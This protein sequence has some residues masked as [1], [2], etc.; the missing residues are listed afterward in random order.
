MELLIVGL[1][2]KLCYVLASKVPANDG[3]KTDA[4]GYCTWLQGATPLWLIGGTQ[5]TTKKSPDDCDGEWYDENVLI[6]LSFPFP[7]AA[8]RAILFNPSGFEC[9]FLSALSLRLIGSFLR[10]DD[11]PANISWF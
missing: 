10:Q 1:T 6:S 5:P 2:T 3:L 4:A 7:G 9:I 8:H 11:G